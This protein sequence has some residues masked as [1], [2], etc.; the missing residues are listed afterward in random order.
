MATSVLKKITARTVMGKF[1][2]LKAGEE[3]PLFVV[4]GRAYSVK[5]GSTQ[6]G[7]WRGFEGQFLAVRTSDGERVKSSVCI[8]PDIATGEIWQAVQAVEDGGCVEFACDVGLR[9]VER[10]GDSGAK[11]EFTVAFH[12]DASEVDP[13]DELSKRLLPKPEKGDKA[14]AA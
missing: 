12:R 9:G 6:Y 3:Q 10:A 11:Y 8:L 4:I 13:L 7:E 2:A 14:K 5:T 1:P